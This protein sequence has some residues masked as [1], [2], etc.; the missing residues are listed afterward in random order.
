MKSGVSQREKGEGGSYRMKR[1]WSVDK[2]YGGEESGGGTDIEDEG[3]CASGRETVGFDLIV[4]EV[5][6]AALRSVM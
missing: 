2:V 1:D 3:N 6:M 4:D 5:S